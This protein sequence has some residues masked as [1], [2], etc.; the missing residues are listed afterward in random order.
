MKVTIELDPGET[1]TV[2]ADVLWEVDPDP[3]AE[4][5]EDEKPCV[6]EVVA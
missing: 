5:D 4:D 1:V 6:V 2:I 3:G